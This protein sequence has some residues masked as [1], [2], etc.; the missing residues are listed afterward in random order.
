MNGFLFSQLG[1]WRESFNE[2]ANADLKNVMWK[3]CVFALF[4]DVWFQWKMFKQFDLNRSFTVPINLFI[5]SSFSLSKIWSIFVRGITA[6][7]LKIFGFVSCNTKIMLRGFMCMRIWKNV[8]HVNV[9]NH[10]Q[11]NI[12]YT[13]FIIY[14]NVNI[15]SRILKTVVPLH[16]SLSKG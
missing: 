14:N 5:G 3:M 4:L 6:C 12:M 11:R 15:C 7:G 8:H 10:C 16:F 13:A 9:V 2:M 1:N